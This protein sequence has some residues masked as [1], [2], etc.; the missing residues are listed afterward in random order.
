MS[1]EQK[2]ACG[3]EEMG[4][5]LDPVTQASLLNY[6]ALMQKWNKVYNLTAV[7]EPEKMVT[8]HLLDSLAFCHTSSGAESSTSAPGPVCRES[9]WR[10]RTRHWRLPCWTATIRNQFSTASLSGVRPG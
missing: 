1:L 3:L 8:Q 4:L 2:L 6:L 5:D 10:W 9:L 7:R